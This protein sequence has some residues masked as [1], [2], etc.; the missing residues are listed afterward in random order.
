MAAT[1]LDDDT[2]APP[3]AKSAGKPWL[4]IGVIAALV[5]ALAV[6]ATLLLA[7]GGKEKAAAV[8]PAK[9]GDHQE[10]EE[11]KGAVVKTPLYL[12]VA[13]PFVVNLNEANAIHFLQVEVSLM[14]YDQPSLDKVKEQLPV[15]RHHLV[16]LFGKQ[17]F[18]DIL[19]EEGKR[20]LQADARTIVQEVLT[21]ATGKPLVEDVY[22]TSIVGQ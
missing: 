4:L 1:D 11:G 18:A 12:E 2:P 3:P 5:A 14:A 17:T 10:S 7:G 20:K 9:G 13:P 6:T 19:S 8:D 15:V 16:V 21:K 22:L